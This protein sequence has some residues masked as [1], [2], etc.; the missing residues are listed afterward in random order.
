MTRSADFAA[1][2][3]THARKVYAFIYHRVQHRETAEDLLSQT[4]LKALERF[5]TFD[6]GKGAFSAW[7]HRI[8]RNAIIDHWRAAKPTSDIEDVWDALRSGED[9]N[10]DAEVRERLAEVE[11]H[12][13]D[14]SPAQRDIVVM[15][16][17][18]QLSYAEIAEIVGSSEDACKMSFSRSLAK[19]RKAM[20]LAAFLILLFPR[21]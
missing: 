3:D 21:I 12:L 20:P 9:V 2:Y 7:I 6:A 1:H 19:L 14:L 16:L 17:W 5:D 4:F 11:S 13:K 10:R 8:A 18:D 15:R